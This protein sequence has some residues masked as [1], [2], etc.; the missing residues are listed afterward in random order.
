QRYSA[1]SVYTAL[2]DLLGAPDD[3]NFGDS[4]GAIAEYQKATTIAERAAASDLQNVNGRRVL[5]GC[6]WRLGAIWAEDKP[7]VAL[8]CSRKAVGISEDLHAVDPMNAEYRYHASR[9]YLA[10][11]ASLHKLGRHGEAIQAFKHAIEHQ[12]A[13]EAVSPER[14][15]NLRVLSRTY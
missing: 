13:I 7:E 4:A 1:I 12:D 15:F 10:L 11:G 5:V 3:P 6:V 14:V 2:G 9:G 8:E